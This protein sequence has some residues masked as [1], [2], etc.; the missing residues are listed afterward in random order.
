M[1]RSYY[2]DVKVYQFVKGDTDGCH[3]DNNDG[4]SFMYSIGKRA[5]LFTKVQKQTC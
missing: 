2:V 1:L 5:C 3:K 4:L